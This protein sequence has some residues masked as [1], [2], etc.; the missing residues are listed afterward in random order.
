MRSASRR[1]GSR[2]STTPLGL[3]RLSAD[4][5]TY[6]SIYDPK[7]TLAAKDLPATPGLVTAAKDMKKPLQRSFWAI[8]P[9][10]GTNYLQAWR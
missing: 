3:Y 6:V 7:V 5:Q 2:A 1:R 10:D 8:D 9:R 4:G